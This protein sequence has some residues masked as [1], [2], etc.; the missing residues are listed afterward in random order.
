M[1]DGKK[2]LCWMICALL[3]WPDG[4]LMAQTLKPLTWDQVRQEFEKNNPTLQAGELSISESRAQEIS[5][6]LR[7]NPSLDLSEDGT[8]LAPY[9]QV[10]QPLRGTVGVATLS[11][12]HERHHKRE[13]RLQSAQEGT[14]IAVSD[15]ADL[16]RTLLFNLR[17]AFVAT[18]EAK[19]IFKLAKDNL[20][21][22]DRILRI[23]R[24]RFQAGDISR[25]DLDRLELQR[26]QFESDLQTAEVNLRTAKIEL[27]TLLDDRTPVSQFD[28]TGLFEF[29]N[30]LP[31][32]DEVRKI[33]LASRPDLKAAMQTIQQA[34]T[35]HKLAVANGSTD[36]TFSAWYSYNPSFNNPFDRQTFGAGVNIPLRLFDRNQG[37]KLRT[38]LDIERSQRLAEATQ[39]QVFSDV[40]SAYAAVNS[41]L[42]LLLSYKAKYLQQA[43]HVRETVRFSYERGG[44]SLLDFLNAE[45]DYRNV[46]LSYLN[47]IGSYMTAAAQLNLAAGREVLP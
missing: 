44:A 31:P 2:R 29:N 16:R 35:N 20:A 22:W 46:E 42:G 4:G 28:V 12:L 24:D 6:D 9:E 40:D 45:D 3:L 26:I 41:D 39:A 34:K 23:S 38:E 8:Q 27:L 33:A 7:P 19:A 43:V 30:Q 21:Y 1:E 47:L 17:R 11:Y 36:P 15:Q 18:L 37:E 13:L 5:A 10:W 14:T 25:I 32:L